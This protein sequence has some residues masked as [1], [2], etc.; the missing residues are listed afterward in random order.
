MNW[1]R[2][3]ESNARHLWYQVS[4]LACAELGR[5]R[6]RVPAAGFEPAMRLEKSASRSERGAST[7]SA[8]GKRVAPVGF[9][10]TVS[11]DERAGHV[12]AR[13]QRAILTAGPSGVE[14]ENAA[15]VRVFA[16]AELSYGGNLFTRSVT[17]EW[18]LHCPDERPFYRRATPSPT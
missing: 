6:R 2:R 3:R 18:D 4:A 7:C 14:P 12:P 8:T 15:R 11:L 13:Y 16:L 9:R 10:P 1:S 17:E 5:L